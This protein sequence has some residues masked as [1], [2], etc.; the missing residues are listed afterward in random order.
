MERLKGMQRRMRPGVM[1]LDVLNGFLVGRVS[2][3][4]IPCVLSV[5]SGFWFLSCGCLSFLRFVVV[6]WFGFFY[7]CGC[8][9]CI[10]LWFA[11]RACLRGFAADLGIDIF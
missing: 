1:R 3:P 7:V 9:W 11:V 2:P 5:V 6:P 4:L 8:S 10:P